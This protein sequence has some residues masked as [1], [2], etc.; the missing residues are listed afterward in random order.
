[1]R[2]NEEISTELAE[3]K[4]DSANGEFQ[5][6][7]TTGYIRAL[8]WVLDIPNDHSFVFRLAA[9]QHAID[10]TNQTTVKP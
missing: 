9:D 2:S 10:K 4:K 6:G 5:N 1:M 3:R 7:W 8:E